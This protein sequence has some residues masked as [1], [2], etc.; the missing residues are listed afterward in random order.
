MLQPGQLWRGPELPVRPAVQ[1]SHKGL[2]L[3]IQRAVHT[4][5]AITATAS[6]PQAATAQPTRTTTGALTSTPAPVL[7]QRH[8]QP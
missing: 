3:A 2:R 5:A 6:K 7:H 1:H 8:Q 4:T